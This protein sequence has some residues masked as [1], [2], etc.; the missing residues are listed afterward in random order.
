MV[1][2]R[3][4]ST[5]ICLLIASI[6]FSQEKR[7]L[8]TD[9]YT[10]KDVSESLTGDHSWLTYPAYSDRESWQKIPEAI[11]AKTIAR[12]AEYLHY[13]WP[14]I[15]P[16]MYL[17]FTRSGDRAIVD[18]AI[19]ARLNALRSLTLAELMEGK[20]R[21]VDDIINGVFSYCEQTYWG[22]SATFYMYKTGFKGLDKPNTVLPDI[23][24][25][26]VDLSAGDAASDLAWIWY[27][28]HEEFDQISPVISK[29]LKSELQKKILDPFY[30][31]YD[32][33]WITGWGEG[34]VNNWTPWCNYNVLTCI[35]L[36]EDDP[37]KKQDGIYKTMASVDLFINSY[38]EDGGCSEGPSYWGVAGGKLFDYLNLLKQVTVGNVDIF[39]KEIVRNIGRYIYRVY[40]S[41]SEKGQYYT[42]FADSPGLMWHDAGRIFRYGKTIEDKELESFGAFLL[43]ESDFTAQP[44]SGRIGEALE[45]LFNLERWQNT[46]PVEPLVGAYYFPDLDLAVA[47]EAAGTTDGF[48]FAAKGG[49]NGE[50]HNHNDVGS[51]ILFYDGKP[52]IVDVGVGTY[53]AK[54]FSDQ[55]YTIWTMQSLYHN[56]PVI[57]GTAQHQGGN[58]SAQ[59]SNFDSSKTKTSFSTDI[60]GAYPQ[61]GK[62]EK[63]TRS[64]TLERGKRFNI[65]D[66]YKLTENTG[67]TALHFMTPL[68]I[69]ILK[70]G[71]L[72]LRGDDIVL[73]MKYNPSV[74]AAEIELKTL[75]D[76]RLQRVWEGDHITRIVFNIQNKALAG[77]ISIDVIDAR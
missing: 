72:E 57:N 15:T 58:F 40:I 38:P 46:Q 74:L 5:A 34:S 23:D 68:E 70:P 12:G 27:F 31:R 3:I 2:M 1:K 4:F 19:S 60:S 75:D 67:G 33:W 11:R 21:F 63:W 53:T 44:I 43:A 59:N 22:M 7:D 16:T 49:S 8:L 69:N 55:R 36:L 26:I 29:R 77:D 64:Y 37:L 73:N 9:F 41:G 30:E 17:E 65:K 10:R 25:P 66:R 50:Q 14:T 28:F 35:A 24:D 54:T 76:N 47:R 20:G 56:L 13:S 42:N 61:E 52:A 62:V 18:G 48:Y 71:L 45:N 32:F 51:F 6:A 39:D